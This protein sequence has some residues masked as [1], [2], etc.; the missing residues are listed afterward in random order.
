MF[1]SWEYSAQTKLPKCPEHLNTPQGKQCE[2]SPENEF[3]THHIILGGFL[4]A[5]PRS[6]GQPCPSHQDEFQANQLSDARAESSHAFKQ[7]VNFL[8]KVV[9]C[10]FVRMSHV[11]LWAA[12]AGTVGFQQIC[13]LNSVRAGK[14]RSTPALSVLPFPFL[15]QLIVGTGKQTAGTNSLILCEGLI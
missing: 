3:Q 5:P 9:V 8:R 13:A 11:P 6:W 7:L 1:P 12:L 10:V 14:S 15:G 4:H 2:T